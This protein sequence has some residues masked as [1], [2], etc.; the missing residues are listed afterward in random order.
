MMEIAKKEAISLV[1][2]PL[3]RGW[4]RGGEGEGAGG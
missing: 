1:F 2:L 3:S 4:S